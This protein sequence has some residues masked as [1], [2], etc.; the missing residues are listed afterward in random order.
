M[1]LGLLLAAIG[2]DTV[3]GRLRMTFGFDPL[4]RGVNFLSPSSASSASAR[5]C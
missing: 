5:Y 1:A 2:M 4:M 3:S